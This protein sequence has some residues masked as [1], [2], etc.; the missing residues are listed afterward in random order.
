MK[1]VGVIIDDQLCL[2][3]HLMTKEKKALCSV[4]ALMCM[5]FQHDKSF[6][7]TKL[8]YDASSVWFSH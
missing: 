7:H 3:E 1:Y 6:I 4:A 5:V 2:G 8:W